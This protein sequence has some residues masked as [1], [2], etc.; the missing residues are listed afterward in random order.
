[1]L[2]PFPVPL[3][4]FSTP[5]FLPFASEKVLPTHPST[6]HSHA[7]PTSPPPTSPFPGASSLYRLRCILCVKGF[8]KAYNRT[9][10]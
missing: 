4:E 3:P 2:A 1:M 5:S 6:Q 7:P 9:I 8:L 10:V